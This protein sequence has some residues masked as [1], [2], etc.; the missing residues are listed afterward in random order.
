MPK[1]V[2]NGRGVLSDGVDV[3]FVSRV[4]PIRRIVKPHPWAPP[5]AELKREEEERRLKALSEEV[6]E[7]ENAREPAD[8]VVSNEESLLEQDS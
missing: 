5:A 1:K 4:S 3:K 2:W 8:E 6:D 7:R